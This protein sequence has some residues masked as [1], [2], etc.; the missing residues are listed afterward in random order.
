[1]PKDEVVKIF[2]PSVTNRNRLVVRI[3]ETALVGAGG[4]KAK[5]VGNEGG[6]L[7]ELRISKRRPAGW[8]PRYRP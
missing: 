7:L 6:E 5:K 4:R 3:D 1:M 2:L 8:G